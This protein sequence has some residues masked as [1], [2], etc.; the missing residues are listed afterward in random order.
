MDKHEHCF[1]KANEIIF[2]QC[3]MT[4][5]ENAVLFTHNPLLIHKRTT[6][7]AQLQKDHI[8]EELQP[9]WLELR[10]LGV[11]PVEKTTNGKAILFIHK[12]NSNYHGSSMAR[13]LGM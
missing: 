3:K 4:R 8:Y 13:H 10:V 6:P 2:P 11:L 12:Y 7:S 9:L 1:Q 5:L